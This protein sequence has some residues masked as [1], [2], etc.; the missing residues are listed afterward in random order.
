MAAKVGL[1][2]KPPRK[3]AP[4]RP[5]DTTDPIEI[6]MVAAA[7]GRPIPEV[8]RRVLEEQAELIHAQRADLRLRHIGEIVRAALW[9]MLAILAFAFVVI[10]GAAVIRAAR[11]D[12][13]IVE[14][15][16][17]PPSLES[18]GLTGEVVATQVLDQIAQLQEQTQSVR[19]QS[20]Y[21]NNWGDDLKIDIP[22]TG[23]TVEEFWTLLRG[24]LGKET[25]IS[26]EVIQRKDGLALTTRVG[27]APGRRIVSRT[28]NLDALVAQGAEHIYRRT[29]PYRYAIY[30]GGFPER[31]Q[32]SMA[33]LRQLTTD[34]SPTERKW[35]FNGLAVRLRFDGD[36]RGSLAAARRALEIDPHMV[37][38]IG[39]LA[40]AHLLLGHAQQALDAAERAL[41]VEQ[42]EEYDNEMFVG[43]L[44]SHYERV[45]RLSMDPT[46]IDQAAACL[47]SAPPSSARQIPVIARAPLLRHDWR[48]AATVR[49][50][51]DDRVSAEEEVVQLL[52]QV[53]RGHLPALAEA[54][55]AFRAASQRRQ[56]GTRGAFHRAAAPVR[57]WP[58]EAL[59]LIRLGRTEEAA[60]LIA[61]TPVDCYDCVRVRGLVAQARGDLP[62]AQRWF[63]E[64]VRQGPRL[65]PAYVDWGRL[66][67]RAR[68]YDSAES[69]LAR[70]AQ[71]SPNWADPLKYWADALAAQNRRDEALAKYDAALRLAPKWEELR[72]ERAKLFR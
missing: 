23:A 12:V 10:V 32:E 67:I 17:V 28:N 51:P 27:S 37:P 31:R 55:D 18:Q 19:A 8:A 26:G 56:T 72:R 34:S 60:A 68:R 54:L 13:L 58:Y 41:I 43:L 48:A 59:A 11:A 14:S 29:Q 6:A 22:Q 45:G 33:I 57:D 40:A 47:Q 53:E 4:E 2:P 46:R 36:L 39:N 16:R 63:S 70:A 66:L 24:W 20:S 64:A 42:P 35:A 61:R 3:S 71:L 65:S 7:S 5:P 1:R 49:R 21:E 25:R 44:C 38:A 30:L 15:F 62:A 9:G 69:K 50:N 52:V